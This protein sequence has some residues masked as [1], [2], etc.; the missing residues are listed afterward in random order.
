MEGYSPRSETPAPRSG[1]PRRI[2]SHISHAK[3][4]FSWLKLKLKFSLTQCVPPQVQFLNFWYGVLQKRL[5]S[6]WTQ[7]FS[8]K[9]WVVKLMERLFFQ[10][11]CEVLFLKSYVLNY[12]HQPKDRATHAS[13][14]L[15]YF[16]DTLRAISSSKSSN[17]LHELM[18]DERNDDEVTIMRDL[19]RGFSERAR[20][21]S[22]KNFWNF[23]GDC[24]CS[25]RFLFRSFHLVNWFF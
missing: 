17:A 1:I 5:M 9:E 25:Y 22:S 6:L 21:K 14:C 12:P 13:E 11:P 15:A 8:G 24:F 10:V 2:R 3:R 7:D 19:L 20:L 4:Y 16:L 18:W 23:R